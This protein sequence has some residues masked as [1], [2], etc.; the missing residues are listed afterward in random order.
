M[1]DFNNRVSAQRRVLELVNSRAWEGEQLFGLSSKAIERWVSVNRLDARSQLVLL[2]T[3]ASEK[4]FFLA[5]KSQEQITEEYRSI[6]QEFA[7]I[8]RALAAEL[9]AAP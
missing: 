6:S 1:S 2:V 9:A 4:L 3:S 5:N 7:S 8:A